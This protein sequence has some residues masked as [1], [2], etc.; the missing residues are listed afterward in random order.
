VWGQTITLRRGLLLLCVA[1]LYPLRANPT[2]Y[3]CTKRT[4]S[5]SL[6]PIRHALTVRTMFREVFT[7]VSGLAADGVSEI[8]LYLAS[9]RMIPAALRDN[10]YTVEAPTDQFPAKL[11]AFDARHRAVDLEQIDLG[12]QITLAA[13]PPAAIGGSGSTAPARPYEQVDLATGSVAGHPILGHTRADVERAL[14]TPDAAR[15]ALLLYGGTSP[16]AAS[17]IV[18]F[19]RGDRALWLE[20]VDPATTDA[21]LGRLLRLQPPELQKR[22]IAAYGSR[23]ALSFG[24]G[25]EPALVGCSGLFRARSGH[26]DLAFGL[27]PSSLSRTFLRLSAS[28]SR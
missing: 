15:P 20:Y 24:Y 19:G 28:R 5:I 17:L 11:V 26:L 23:Y 18:F 12:N 3:L 1:E 14:G 8:D 27:D 6:L 22:L 2:G 10:V 13:C 7:R 9:G 21:R 16:A 4:S 25:S